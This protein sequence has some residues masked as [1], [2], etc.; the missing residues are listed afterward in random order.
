MFNDR[1][2][3]HSFH[4]LRVEQVCVIISYLLTTDVCT[5]TI[6]MNRKERHYSSTTLWNCKHLLLA[7]LHT[8]L[9][10]VVAHAQFAGNSYV[11]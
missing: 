3:E 2:I 6:N 7:V 10:T 8:V 4:E 9:Y 5:K 1:K 11:S